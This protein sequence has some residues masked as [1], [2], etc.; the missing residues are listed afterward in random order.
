MPEDWLIVTNKILLVAD[1]VVIVI[2]ILHFLRVGK[3]LKKSNKHFETT[4]TDF[5]FAV[6]EQ[7]RNQSE[8][9][10]TQLHIK[11]AEL[12]LMSDA[13]RKKGEWGKAMKEIE[14]RLDQYGKHRIPET[15]KK[16][17]ELKKKTEKYED[18]GK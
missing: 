2:W 11:K 7:K 13:Q 6:Q 18:H 9:D 5:K 3:L 15:E 12:L 17:G 4:Q 14:D 10:V 8:S 16:K 1:I